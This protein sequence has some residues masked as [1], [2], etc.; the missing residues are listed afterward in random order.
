MVHVLPN[1]SVLPLQENV[2][3]RKPQR[4]KMSQKLAVDRLKNPFKKTTGCIKTAKKYTE[5]SDLHL[6]IHHIPKKLHLNMQI[7]S[8]FCPFW[9]LPQKSYAVSFLKILLRTQQLN[10]ATIFVFPA[11]RCANSFP[12]WPANGLPWFRFFQAYILWSDF[13]KKGVSTTA[14]G[15]WI[16]D[17]LF[18]SVNWR[19]STFSD[20]HH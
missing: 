16:D 6:P 11:H 13:K 15:T 1:N 12:H 8:E 3:H 4:K 9:R 19:F 2:K 10:Q 18:P 14:E 7:S 5:P 17:W 20:S